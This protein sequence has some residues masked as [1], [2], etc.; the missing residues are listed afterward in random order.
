MVTTRIYLLRHGIAVPHGTPG[1]DDDDRTLTP[2]G[3]SRVKKIALGLKRIDVEPGTIV[4]S[5]LP[6]AR[7]TAEI[8]ARVLKREDSLVEDDVLTPRSSAAS[9]REWLD[10]RDEDRLMLVGHNPVLGSLLGLLIG[11]T[12]ETPPFELKK[13]GIA[14]VRARPEFPGSYQLQWLATPRLLRHEAG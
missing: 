3:E 7:R 1:V 13:G 11:L 14:E 10:A 12:T 6:R 8:V 2:K 5:P 9:I 4:T